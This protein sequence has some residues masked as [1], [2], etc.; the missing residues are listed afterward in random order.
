MRYAPFFL[1]ILV[2]ALYATMAVCAQPTYNGGNTEAGA[3]RPLQQGSSP[4]TVPS[5]TAIAPNIP[6]GQGGAYTGMPRDSYV[7]PPSG[8][9][10][11]PP[12]Y[13]PNPLYMPGK[14]LNTGRPFTG[15]PAWMQEGSIPY[16]GGMYPPF[17]ANLFQGYFAGTYYEGMNENY[18]ITPGDR[19]LVHIWGAHA[20]SDTLMVDQQGNIFLPEVGPVNVAGMRHSQLQGKVRSFIAS[21]FT[22]N[23]EVYVNLLTA[24]PVAVYVTGFVQRPG[25]YAGGMSDSV[26]YYLDRAGGIIPDRGSYRDVKIQRH[27]STVATV[28]LYAFILSGQIRGGRLQDGD[29]IV[30]GPKGD[31]IIADGLIPQHAS[32]EIKGKGGARGDELIALAAPLPAVSHVSVRG[33]R[34]MV[35]FHVYLTLDGFKKFHLTGSDRIEFLA[36]RPGDSIM[37]S[38][39]GSTLGATHYPVRRNTT[40]RTLLAHVP[41]DS[42]LSNLSGIYLKRKSVVE[43][44]RKAIHDALRRLESSVLTATSANQEGAAIRVEE[45]K[46]VQ[47]FV[48]RAAL[49]EPDGVVVV[50]RNGV[51]ADIA[52]EDG[53]EVVIPQKSDVVHISGEVMIPKAVVYVKGQ[54]VRKYITEAGGLTDRGDSSNILVVHPNGEIAEAGSTKILPG[55]MLLVMPKYDSKGFSIFKDIMQVIYQLAISTKVILS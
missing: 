7:R 23:V 39:S 52:L 36:D 16:Q 21:T 28:D 29:V 17:G 24:Q 31:S 54:T 6:S 43:Q 10:P 22:S 13:G 48:R 4:S 44:Q 2:L 45:A 27:N 1:L 41:V 18:I 37:V 11:V 49:V 42:E 38:V 32:F 47:D 8:Y 26:L 5:E 25:R 3:P 50:T 33:T 55:D 20:Y 46:L 51:T 34:N 19:I 30:V 9:A 40:L 53:D 35:P 14:T 12:G 15:S